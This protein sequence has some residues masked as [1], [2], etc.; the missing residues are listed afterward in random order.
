MALTLSIDQLGNPELEKPLRSA[1]DEFFTQYAGDW[2]VTIIGSL[3]SAAWEMKV[4]ASAGDNSRARII[5][6]KDGGH[7]I[8]R[9]VS[10]IR[11][12]AELLSQSIPDGGKS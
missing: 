12:M 3:D 5:S 9:V 8:E 4:S 6:A 11:Q 10:E 7:K 1:I 2:E